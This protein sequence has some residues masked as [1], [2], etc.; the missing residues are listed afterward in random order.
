MNKILVLGASGTV[1]RL[2]VRALVAQGQAVK[3]AS[4]TGRAVAGAEAVR[5]D[6]ADRATHAPAFEG[7]DTGSTC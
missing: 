6:Y 2:L 4:R 5:F 1:G 3:A 7:V